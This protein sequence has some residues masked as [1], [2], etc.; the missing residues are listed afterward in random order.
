MPSVR[1][2]RNTATVAAL[3]PAERL[4]SHS[5]AVRGSAVNQDDEARQNLQKSESLEGRND[6]SQGAV[7]LG[8]PVAVDNSKN[9]G[10][11]GQG[12]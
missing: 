2:R 11:A 10:D 12:E 9:A 4:R 5:T 3:V 8:P 7:V 6:S 1:V